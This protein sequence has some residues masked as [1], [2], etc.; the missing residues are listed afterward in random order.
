[1]DGQTSQP[2]RLKLGVTVIR[3]CCSQDFS[4]NRELT[5]EQLLLLLRKM[6]KN[7]SIFY[8][9]NFSLLSI[10]ECKLQR[11][12]RRSNLSTTKKIGLINIPVHLYTQ[13]HL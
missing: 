11:L 12:G 9:T 10:I 8:L 1:M 6:E 5:V 2:R 7:S 4:L 13:Q 3:W